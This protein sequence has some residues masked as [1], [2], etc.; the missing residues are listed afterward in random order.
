MKLERLESIAIDEQAP[1]GI[2]LPNSREQREV[3]RRALYIEWLVVLDHG[4]CAQRIEVA[5]R[6]FD[7]LAKHLETGESEK[8]ARLAGIVAVTVHGEGECFQS[9]R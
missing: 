3:H 4:D 2:P 5:R 7:Y 8:L 6:D 1:I 9:G